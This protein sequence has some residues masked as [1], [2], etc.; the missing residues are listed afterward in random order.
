MR[1]FKL[2][3]TILFFGQVLMAAV[4][5]S[6]EVKGVKVPVIFEEDSRLPIASLQL[7]FKNS[8]S[9]ED[10]KSIGLAKM[11]AKM[12]N[13]GTKELGS[14]EFAEA[15]DSKAI[16]L[17]AHTGTETFVFELSSL[18]EEFSNALE[19]LQGLLTSPNLTNE[20]LDK[21][22]TI[23]IGGLT[24]KENDFDYIANVALKS[25]L[26]KDT[27]LQ[28][29]TSGTIESVKNSSLKD[30]QQFLKE[31][32]VLSRAI[33]VVGGDL[34]LDEVEKELIAMLETLEVGKSDEVE[35]YE[36]SKKTSDEIIIKKTE[37]AYVYF[38]SP[39]H[40][41]VD[42][43]EYY[44]ARVAT[45]ILGTGGFGSRLMEEIRVKRGL[46]YSAYARINIAAS[47]N[48]MMGYLQTKL[49]SMK[50]AQETVK[51]VV[52]T[53]VKEGVTQEELDQAKKF[54]L[55][56]EPLRVE[57]LSQRLSRTF[58]EYYKGQEIGASQKELEKI[59]LLDLKTLNEFIKSHSE[60]TKLSFAIVTAK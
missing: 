34:A 44:K 29:P 21:V 7:V 31:H 36:V 11:S 60:I 3:V 1:A 2:V 22:K 28:N 55:G 56:S 32:I 25:L 4:I 9:I 51:E 57:T 52:E 24:R 45:F 30:V 12:M 6:I 47:S 50:E 14:V 41:H 49:E 23:T 19:L 43:P 58:M 13:E 33:V 15:L 10:G 27:P 20:S 37:Q 38:G 5:D 59:E 40:L 46:A 53:F 26:F 8:G 17:S 35:H 18:K 16:A 39:Y 42:S 54:L 48:Y